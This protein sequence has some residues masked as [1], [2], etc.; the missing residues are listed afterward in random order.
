[1]SDCTNSEIFN[2][3]L[4]ASVG[5]AI[6]EL[7]GE[8][9]YA[10]EA[11]AKLHRTV[12]QAL[13]G[14]N[15]REHPIDQLAKYEAIHE[16]FVRGERQELKDDISLRFGTETEQWFSI[17]STLVR[18]A[19]G[20]PDSIVVIAHD[21][22]ERKHAEQKAK[23]MADRLKAIHDS[24]AIG[25]HYFKREVPIAEPNDAFLAM[26]GLTQDQVDT[27]SL[28]AV[29]PL[30]WQEQ[31]KIMSDQLFAT[32][33][34]VAYLKEIV[35]KRSGA[36][37]PVSVTATLF[38]HDPDYEGVS[39][40]CD[41]SDLFNA[42]EEAEDYRRKADLALGATSIGLWDLSADAE[43]VNLDERSR[44]IFGLGK[45]ESVNF[46]L[47]REKIVAE[48]LQKIRTALRQVVESD[49][50]MSISVEFRLNKLGR[51]RIVCATGRNFRARTS[52]ELRV[53]GTLMDVT[54]TK[55]FEQRILESEERF[56]TLAETIPQIVFTADQFGHV[57]YVNRKWY[58]FTGQRPMEKIT[59]EQ[60]REA[61]CPADLPIVREK[62]HKALFEGRAFEIEYRMKTSSGSFRWVIV[63]ASPLL[64]RTG[65]TTRW[66]GS[67][68]DIDSHRRLNDE[69]WI[70][71]DR[72]EKA[73]RMKSS[74]LA[75][76]SH[77]IRTP[78]GAILGF[79]ELLG[80][81]T[82][83]Q[84]D[85]NDYLGIVARNSRS[86]SRIVD[87][88]L[89]LSKVEAGLL[90]LEKTA[91]CP[92]TLLRDIV[93]LFAERARKK[94]LVIDF[95]IA[96]DVPASLSSDPMRIRQ[97]VNNLLSNSLKFTEKGGISIDLS[98][99]GQQICISVDDSGAGISPEYVETLFQ[100]FV[101]GD[102]KLSRKHGGTGLGLHLSRKLAEALGGS[103][104]FVVKTSGEGSR[105]LLTLPLL[106]ASMADA[107][108]WRSEFGNLQNSTLRD[109][110]GLRIL[111]VDDAPDNRK[112]IERLLSRTGAHVD[113]AEDGFAGV[114][115]ATAHEYDLILMDL[116]MPD[117]DGFEAT[118]EIRALN[119][120]MPI[121]ALT[122]HAVDEVR[123]RCDRAGFNGFLTKPINSAALLKV[124]KELTE[125]SPGLIGPKP[126]TSFVT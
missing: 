116:Q 69:L 115:Q 89:D 4:G 95:K 3:L 108:H 93:A 11:F 28:S 124:V 71:R 5:L 103:L 9:R 30:D 6:V 17:E 44:S 104:K 43:E 121:V 12:P 65:Q 16:E 40:V 68:T 99:T 107:D 55:V 46:P 63:R 90:T 79:T 113:Y 33:R 85:R 37:I 114:A 80:D 41:L 111:V 31:D 91:F 22:T 62:W 1:V 81:G 76:M 125:S 105:F 18:N 21:V 38:E 45:T 83:S 112:L 19:L 29:T 36:V 98:R 15:F 87:D 42:R 25:M 8:F 100:P 88:V 35:S 51:E 94:G 57:N 32:R 48:D 117:L 60:I 73:S 56:R 26:A 50:A 52:G 77:E 122:A 67:C 75:N 49:S 96:D 23:E 86:L 72:A 66:F 59:R 109:L 119:L 54:E 97:I 123:D 78:L 10:N 118:K 13:V 106:E 24:D 84:T 110:D 120:A 74:F 82:L 20:E 70:E 39:L 14:R 101:Q 34:P 61:I 2:V 58:D 27:Q 53:V 7:S 92:R 47:L 126:S 64:D 102:E